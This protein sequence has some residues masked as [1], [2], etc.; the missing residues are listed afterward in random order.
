MT[1][2]ER[3]DAGVA[4]VEPVC[5]RCGDFGAL[6]R[7]ST[8]QLCAGCVERLPE[9]IRTPPSLGSLL[10]G[11]GWTLKHSARYAVPIAFGY[12][13]VETTLP[14][15]LGI[16]T[17]SFAMIVGTVLQPF[18]QLMLLA[19]FQAALH[20]EPIELRDAGRLAVDRYLS[21][22]F[23]TFY[24]G[25]I[26]GLAALALLVPGFIYATRYLVVPAVVAFEGKGGGTALNRSTAH[27]DGVGWPVAGAM[28]VVFFPPIVL[29]VGVAVA[30]E[31]YA[32]GTSLTATGA[33]TLLPVGIAASMAVLLGIAAL[34]SVVYA[35]RRFHAPSAAPGPAAPYPPSSPRATPA[36]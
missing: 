21:L 30:Y 24:S 7:V 22:L 15:I 4:S 33:A 23:T 11:V 32:P 5:E 9:A 17:S 3:A 14:W 1:S 12:A 13:A 27:V 28:A 35:N 36:P 2:E 34:V 31:L 26:I 19:V 25:L 16:Q 10:L 29:N 8:R 6:R 18:A 20:Q